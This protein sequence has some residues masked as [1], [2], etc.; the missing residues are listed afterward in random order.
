[1]CA[2]RVLCQGNPEITLEAV[3]EMTS[4]VAGI[5]K[6]TVYRIRKEANANANVP[7]NPK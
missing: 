7:S 1:M 3:A 2:E 6:A 5:G 4:Q